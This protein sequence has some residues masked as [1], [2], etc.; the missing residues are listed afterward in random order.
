MVQ[1]WRWRPIGVLVLLTASASERRLLP[2]KDKISTC[3][4]DF[5]LSQLLGLILKRRNSNG[6][7]WK[8]TKKKAIWATVGCAYRHCSWIAQCSGMLL[9]AMV[10]P[11]I[12]QLGRSFTWD[13]W[14]RR[15]GRV[16]L[17]LA[18]PLAGSPTRPTLSFL[19]VLLSFWRRF[20][21]STDFVEILRI[22]RW[23]CA[24]KY[25]QLVWTKKMFCC[26]TRSINLTLIFIYIYATLNNY[27]KCLQQYT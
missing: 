13:L 16:A 19:E 6:S 24:L 18:L 20:Q 9:V 11:T 21:V 7:S 25:R 27:R 23:R 8:T 3:I 4:S 1:L 17:L 12:F 22:C 5:A 15:F 26:S 14:W 2:K 10:K